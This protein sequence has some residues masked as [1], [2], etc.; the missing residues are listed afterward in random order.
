MHYLYFECRWG[1]PSIRIVSNLTRQL[2]A[3]YF[4]L[5]MVPYWKRR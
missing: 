3:H 2:H 5:L 4:I 1:F